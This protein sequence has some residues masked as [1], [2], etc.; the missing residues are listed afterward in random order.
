M[1]NP[2]RISKKKSLGDDQES[3]Q[4]VGEALKTHIHGNRIKWFMLNDSRI[5]IDRKKIDKTKEFLS[6]RKKERNGIV[7]KN[8]LRIVS[9]IN[10]TGSVGRIEQALAIEMGNYLIMSSLD[11]TLNGGATCGAAAVYRPSSLTSRTAAFIDRVLPLSLLPSP[12]N[13]LFNYLT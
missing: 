8:T 2:Q 13:L 4:N 11:W 6:F 9:I 1:K 3:L 10:G 5:L 12:T 7:E